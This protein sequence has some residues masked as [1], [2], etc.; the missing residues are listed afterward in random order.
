MEMLG[1]LLHKLLGFALPERA[2]EN[3]HIV[4]NLYNFLNLLSI[5]GTLGFIAVMVFFAVRYHKTQ[6]DKSAY[7]PHNTM[8]EAIWTIVPT[9]IFVAVAVWGLWAYWER[10]KYPEDAMHINVTGKQ[11]MWE[12]TYKNKDGL[13]ASITDVLYLPVNTPIVLD[14]TSVDVLHSFWVPAF[15]VKRDT[16]PGM[17]T[18]ITF[19]PNKIG[20]YKAYCTEYCGTSHSRMRATV[21]VVSK[22]R[23]NKWLNYEIKE[24][25][26]SDPVELGS[27]LFN[28]KGCTSCHSV[29]SNKII[30]PGLANLF[31]KK[32]E[33]SNADSV[34]ADNEY[35]RE[36]ILNPNAKVVKGYPAKMNSFAG[37][38]SEKEIGYLID[39]IKTLK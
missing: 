33:F 7:I 10:E 39:Y 16:V 3:A 35:I 19:T 32:R 27:R 38:L 36:S 11:W 34:V 25:N 24:A 29:G 2:S 18:R 23:F 26:I 9:I 14:M 31:G 8:A 21:K 30:G 4:D 12:F 15:R 1:D 20:E 22:E 17:K 5:V 28:R 13:E 6:N 37:Q